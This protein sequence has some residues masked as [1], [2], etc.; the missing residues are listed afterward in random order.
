MVGVV[1]MARLPFAPY[2]RIQRAF[3]S[4]LT[5]WSTTPYPLAQTVI[6]SLAPGTFRL[7]W[8]GLPPAKRTPLL[9]LTEPPLEMST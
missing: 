4:S 3:V 9:P 1:D 6:G 5:A 2:G 8:S 7:Q